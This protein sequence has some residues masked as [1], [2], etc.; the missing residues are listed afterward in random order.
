MKKATTGFTIVELLIVIAVIA[1]LAT[2]SVIAY[3]GV[4]NRARLAAYRH[5]ANQIEKQITIHAIQENGETASITS[6]SL[7]G[8]REE[9]GDIGLIEPITGVQDITM[10]AVL[11]G[12]GASNG[13][14]PYA[15]LTPL[16]WDSAVFSLDVGGAGTTT[17]RSR[18]DTSLQ[19]NLV[20]SSPAGFYIPGR[21]VVCWVEAQ[22]ASATLSFACNQGAAQNSRSFTASHAG[23]SFTGLRLVDRSDD[24]KAG[25]IFKDAHDTTTRA[26]VVSWLAKKYN[27]SL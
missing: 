20:T 3:N 7:V 11:A 1:V 23:W 17:M 14:S 13:Y 8:V 22:H 4:Q 21:T 19:S 5:D 15:Y 26:Q 10:Y 18:I 2:I 6:G 25:L 24:V 9:A 27:V 16:V 12:V